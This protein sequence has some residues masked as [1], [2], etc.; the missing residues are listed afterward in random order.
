MENGTKS[1]NSIWKRLWTKMRERFG[2]LELYARIFIEKTRGLLNALLYAAWSWTSQVSC[3]LLVL[4]VNILYSLSSRIS[5]KKQNHGQHPGHGRGPA[6]EA[7]L[8]KSSPLETSPD[9]SSAS[10]KSL[11]FEGKQT[12]ASGQGTEQGHTTDASRIPEWVF[13]LIYIYT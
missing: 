3:D 5:K 8:V 7:C 13:D 11:A 12:P 1:Q 4:P 2:L 6:K 9:L 10:G